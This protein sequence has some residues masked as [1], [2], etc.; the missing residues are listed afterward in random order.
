MNHLGR[1]CEVAIYVN[2]RTDVQVMAAFLA[3]QINLKTLHLLSRIQSVD[4]MLDEALDAVFDN[5]RQ[6]TELEMTCFNSLRWSS[7]WFERLAKS[8]ITSLKIICDDILFTDQRVY[9]ENSKMRRLDVQIR[10]FYNDSTIPLIEAFTSLKELFIFKVTNKIMQA[11]LQHQVRNLSNDSGPDT[12]PNWVLK[13]DDGF[14]RNISLYSA[15]DLKL[16][17]LW[18][19]ER[20]RT[21]HSKKLRPIHR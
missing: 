2:D 13:C 5:C 20:L 6:L 10:S 9:P 14:Y 11:V 15:L 1:L 21:A 7:S 17:Y 4:N 3:R 18:N 8:S 12:E 19:G 16:E